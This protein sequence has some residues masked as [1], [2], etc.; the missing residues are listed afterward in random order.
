VDFDSTIS[1]RERQTLL[2]VAFPFRIKSHQPTYEI[3][4]GAMQRTSKPTESR[5]KAKFEVPAQQWVDL[6]ESKFGVSLLNN[7][8]YGFDASNNTLRMTL[9]RSPHYPH[10]L[11]PWRL[12][13]DRCTDQGEHTL[14][15]SLY[16]HHDDWR[17]A[18]TTRRA[19]ELNQPL[20]V[21]EGTAAQIPSLVSVSSPGILIDSIKK[22][23]DS[24]EIIIRMHE[25]HG[26][27]VKTTLTFGLRA[28]AAVECDLMEQD[29]APLKISKAKLSLKFAAFEIKTIR[30]KFRPKR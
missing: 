27:S 17:E 3:Q 30:V 24:D 1:W 29:Q 2:K 16:P 26:Q 4:F 23:E 13:D 8:K 28:D 19:R 5:Q 11:E 22:A 7:C 20:M 10:A 9:L 6:S 21:M 12:N 18:E 14:T 15:Y 25:A